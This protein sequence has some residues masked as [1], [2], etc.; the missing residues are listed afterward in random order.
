MSEPKLLRVPK[1]FH[2]VDDV[3]ECAR[4]M[5]LP[6]VVVL[7]ELENGNLVFLET[8]MTLASANWMLDRMKILM[9]AP[10]SHER[11]GD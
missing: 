10:S 6:N 11:V 1:T 8:D 5:D 7:S 2:S 9:L 4:K 3:L